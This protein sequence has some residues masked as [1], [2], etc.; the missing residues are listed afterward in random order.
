[1]NLFETPQTDLAL[2]VRCTKYNMEC[3]VDRGGFL[4]IQIAPQRTTTSSVGCKIV[5]VAT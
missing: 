1:M 4:K 3:E 5:V 2:P